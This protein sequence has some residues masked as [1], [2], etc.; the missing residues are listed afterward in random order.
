MKGYSFS[1]G[2]RPSKM[3]P[4]WSGEIP[5]IDGQKE[6]SFRDLI[7]LRF[8]LAF[9]AEGLSLQTVR[10]CLKTARELL[11]DAHPFSLRRLKTDGRSIFAEALRNV[12]SEGPEAL[13]RELLDL[14]QRQYVFG[15]VIE[16]S[17]K[18]LDFEDD[19]VAR[20]RPYLGKKSI[21][22]DPARAFGQPIVNDAA[23]PTATL[24]DALYAEGSERRV[25]HL[26]SVPVSVVRDAV[27]FEEGL[28]AA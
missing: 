3:A 10:A 27:A 19:L 2:D 22:I 1:K 12:S 4:L 18:D 16:K 15:G 28:N 17:F 20:W 21:V 24:V 5:T 25:A 13:Q 6:L 11:G 14:K 7:E 8:V 26:Y 9:L 23:I